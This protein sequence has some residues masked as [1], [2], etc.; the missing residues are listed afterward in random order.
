M[1]FL[2]I[3][4]NFYD[5]ISKELL[6]GATKV[7]DKEK[8]T[9]Q[10]ITVPGALE[11]PATVSYAADSDIYDGFIALGCVIRGETIHHEIVAKECARGL[12]ELA[13]NLNIAIGNGV[14]SAENKK[15]A[16]ER[17]KVSKKNKGGYAANVAIRMAIIQKKFFQMLKEEEK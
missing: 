17:A 6:S 1:H 8:Y 2:I 3:L 16:I 10:K 11:I 4:A 14:I 5:D 13:M 7:L 15:Q 12:N 9:Y